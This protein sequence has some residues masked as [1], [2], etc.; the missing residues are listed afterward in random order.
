MILQNDVINAFT[1]TLI[2]IPLT[3]N[4]R[5]AT[6]PSSVQVNKGEGG[7]TKDSVILCHQLRVLD[8][9]RLHRKLG[10]VSRK[11]LVEVE[12]RLLFTLGIV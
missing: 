1:S 3:S 12:S 5:R 7:L 4:L 6:L 10:T 11:T 8:K 9:C 2:A